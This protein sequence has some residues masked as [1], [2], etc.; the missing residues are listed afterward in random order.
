[1]FSMESVRNFAGGMI[2][3][4]MERINGMV[5]GAGDVIDQIQLGE[6]GDGGLTAFQRGYLARE[7]IAPDHIEAISD[8]KIRATELTEANPSLSGIEAGMQAFATNPDNYDEVLALEVLMEDE[9][10]SASLAAAIQA[11]QDGETNLVADQINHILINDPDS[12]PAVIDEFRANP[13]GLEGILSARVS[14]AEATA[15]AAAAL[16]LG[17]QGAFME[18]IQSFMG[19]MNL[20]GMMGMLGSMLEAIMP[21]IEG[22]M[23]SLTGFL[24]S[25]D[26]MFVGDGE[27]TRDL[28][29]AEANIENGAL[30]PDAA[31]PARV[32]PT[33][34]NAAELAARQQA[35]AD[36]RIAT[37]SPHAP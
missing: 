13:D 29:G 1:M 2:G 32:G 10:M 9:A 20:D 5:D 31:G 8:I 14:P 18:M 28:A 19:D 3:S 25:N 37:P 35:E 15:A 22:L 24:Q 33:V 21:M 30:D 26:L 12:L 4:G 17:E 36:A 16:E 27:M 7:G 11:G 34:E 23:E 6:A